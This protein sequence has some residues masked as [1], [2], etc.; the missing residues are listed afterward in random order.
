LL[1]ELLL[2]NANGMIRCAIEQFDLPLSCQ[3]V[4][5]IEQT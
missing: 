5:L 4:V 1:Q 2:E 3:R